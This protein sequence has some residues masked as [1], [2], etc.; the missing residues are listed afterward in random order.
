[1]SPDDA[2]EGPASVPTGDK[3]PGEADPYGWVERVV[4]TEPMLERLRT[5]A[6]KDEVWY[7][8]HDKIFREEVLRAGYARVARNGGAAGVDGMTV[9]RFGARLDEEIARLIA[10]WRAGTYRPQA[11][12]RTWIAKPGSDEKR[13]LGIPTV[14]DRVVQAA[15]VMALEPIFERT[16]HPCSHGFR[17]G[18]SA[19]GALA[20]V[21][22]HLNAGRCHVV[23]ADLKSYFDSI[24]HER[25]LRA[26]R[27]RVADGRVL[28]LIGAFLKAGVLDGVDLSE[29]ESGT[30]QGGVISPLLANIY[31]NDLDHTLAEAGL[32]MERYA[33]DFVVLCATPEEAQAALDRVQAWTAAAGLTLHP[34]KTRIVDM[35]QDQAAFD[36]LGFRF[37]RHHGSDGTSRIL[38]LVRPK[39]RKRISDAI[40]ERTPRCLGIG[41][42]ATITAL[43]SVLRGW[44][45]YFR[46]AHRGVHHE[47]D[48][49]VRRR[50]RSMLCKANGIH[51]WGN[52]DANRRW[53]NAYFSG[54]G[55][56]ALKAA[57]LAHVQPHRG[58]SDWRAVCG[59][60]ARTVRREGRP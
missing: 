48:G 33:D 9:E 17:P 18:R 23:D 36:F 44:S 11:V 26:V 58:N 8:L 54:L 25:L 4:W 3:P 12:R 37:Q 14:R 15:L 13:P 50:L 60:T 31:L 20:A 47:L 22:G 46:S 29:P 53:P 28:E 49:F 27:R 5:G 10:A 51:S 45:A 30:P 34:Q 1:V 41:L 43:N 6:G 57:H 59:K 55:L 7:S 39:S 52:G 38:R 35:T 16:F 32:V 24:P 40:R 21:M 19:K 56:F 2:P 42:A